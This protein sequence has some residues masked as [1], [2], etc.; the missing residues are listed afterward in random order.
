METDKKKNV[1]FFYASKKKEV[2]QSSRNQGK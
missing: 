1:G 2:G